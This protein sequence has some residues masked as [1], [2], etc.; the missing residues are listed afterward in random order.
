[1]NLPSP[2]D[3]RPD[4]PWELEPSSRALASALAHAAAG[5]PV[6]ATRPGT[7]EPALGQK[8]MRWG[9]TDPETIR[10]W[11]RNPDRGIGLVLDHSGLVVLDVD[12]PVV[13]EKSLAQLA[14]GDITSLPPTY[15]VTSTRG[16]HLWYRIPEGEEVLYRT[17]Q[18]AQHGRKD[19][20]IK[21]TWLLMLPGSV[22]ASGHLYR[23]SWDHVP[24]PEE[25]PFLPQ[26]VW[27]RIVAGGR[28]RT[29]PSARSIKRPPSPTRGGAVPVE[30]RSGS[31]VALEG[32]EGER[33]ERRLRDLSHGKDD[34]IYK[35]VLTL[36]RH[37]AEVGDVWATVMSSPLGERVRRES[38]QVGYFLHKVE[39]ARDCLGLEGRRWDRDTWL[40]RMLYA[41][42]TDP[43]VRVLA[44]LL[45]YSDHAGVVSLGVG[46]IAY[47]SALSESQ[48]ATVT[49]RLITRGWVKVLRSFDSKEMRPRVLALNLPAGQIPDTVSRGR[50]TTSP[51]STRIRDLTASAGH[52]AFRSAGKSLG[53]H[54]RVLC[55][56]EQGVTTS[57]GLVEALRCDAR[58]VRRYME[59]LFRYRLVEG[60]AAGYVLAAGPLRPLLDAVASTVGTAG[61][62]AAQWAI[63]LE[64]CERNTR[65]RRRMGIVGTE[66][67]RDAHI[68]DAVRSLST[69][70]MR[71]LL[72][73]WAQRGVGTEQAAEMM[74]AGL[75]ATHA[76]AERCFADFDWSDHVA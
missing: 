58:T 61:R 42:L 66:E 48:A 38:D 52:D 40:H 49:N 19:L 23:G 71:P 75:E 18:G 63:Y 41:G 73:L 62:G 26:D 22:S 72:D 16:R 55:L 6:V 54:F 35:V 34:R 33:L 44:A 47:R 50:R 67:W 39:S 51:L 20:D 14:D 31:K 11:W 32:A 15:E 36:L 64:K 74:V 7:K 60:D 27:A 24:F 9:T 21:M 1:M 37:G 76:A 5:F 46:K 65:Y 28:P 4:R 2:T 30:W 12:S 70:A 25:L 29:V 68:K 56:I 3:F 59:R 69:E 13:G 57:D 8:R 10:A 53:S 45:E 43:E 17:Q